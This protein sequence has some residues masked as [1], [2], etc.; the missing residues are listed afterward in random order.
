MD[1]ELAR[2]RLAVE[3]EPG[4]RKLSQRLVNALTRAGREA[5]AVI[6]AFDAGILEARQQAA[7]CASMLERQRP[8]LERILKFCSFTQ[9]S[10]AH[11]PCGPAHWEDIQW[12]REWQWDA[13]A[14]LAKRQRPV[15]GL[16][17]PEGRAWRKWKLSGWP[18]LVVRRPME[19]TTFKA[20]GALPHLREIQGQLDAAAFHSLP[21]SEALRIV[22]L[23]DVRSLARL[24]DFPGLRALKLPGLAL[25]RRGC[26]RLAGSSVVDIYAGSLKALSARGLE[27]LTEL[28]TLAIQGAECLT[29]DHFSA[30]SALTKLENLSLSTQGFSRATTTRA[31]LKK[32]SPLKNLKRLELARALKDGG[33]EEVGQLSGLEVLDIGHNRNV[34][35]TALE[36]LAPLSRLRMLDLGG[37][38][39]TDDALDALTAFPQLEHLNLF[40]TRVSDDGLKILAALPSLR[41]LMLS[42]SGVS[43]RAAKKALPKRITVIV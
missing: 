30:L 23:S 28:R 1:E 4:D 14:P 6:A 5:E 18:L 26:Q 24:G 38:E 16:D 10:T 43:E 3:K 12:P 37:T 2:L 32:L 20:L 34:N 15:L 40:D 29:S 17:L 39:L 13:A 11:Y 35:R 27:G 33:F 31:R 22:E 42:D 41:Y 9:V 25:D 21:A 8:L 36:A 7:L 19:E